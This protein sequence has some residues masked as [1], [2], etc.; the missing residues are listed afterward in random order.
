MLYKTTKYSM[1]AEFV[2]SH[3]FVDIFEVGRIPD[4]LQFGAV[5]FIMARFHSPQLS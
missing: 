1:L 4:F 3:A 2:G 5:R